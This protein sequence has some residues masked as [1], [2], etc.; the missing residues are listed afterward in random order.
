M[1][2]KDQEQIER[3]DVLHEIEA[4]M[5]FNGAVCADQ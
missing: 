4:T 5:S 3:T 2:F 1:F